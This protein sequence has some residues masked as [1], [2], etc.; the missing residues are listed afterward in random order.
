MVGSTIAVDRIILEL[1]ARLKNVDKL[2]QVTKRFDQV[3]VSVNK[4]GRLID[5][6]SGKMVSFTNT[7]KKL[8]KVQD[9]INKKFEGMNTNMFSFGLSALFTGMAIKRLATG[10]LKAMGNVFLELADAQN[11]GVKRTLELQ[12]AFQF[13]KFALFDALANTDLYASFVGFIIR[14]VRGIID[15]V[16]QNPALAKMFGILLVIG[17]VFGAISMTLGQMTLGFIGIQAGLA[18]MKTNATTAGVAVTASMNGILVPVILLAALL[19]LALKHL[20][21]NPKHVK[22]LR[23]E[24]DTFKETL[25]G[26]WQILSNIFAVFNVELPD[27]GKIAFAL[28]VGLARSFND[29]FRTSLEI[30]QGM[31]EALIGL[32]TFNLARAARGVGQAL[33]ASLRATFGAPFGIIKNVKDVLAEIK[34][35]E[36]LIVTPSTEKLSSNI[37]DTFSPLIPGVQSPNALRSIINDFELQSIQKDL[38]TELSIS[39]SESTEVLKSIQSEGLKLDPVTMRTFAEILAEELINTSAVIAAPE[40]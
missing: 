29:E 7:S 31:I 9:Q 6:A 17:V 14:A 26:F 39:N 5:K 38:L 16:D 11:E 19:F 25:S 36:A 37:G 10:A 28:L 1:D 22:I 40:Q 33:S 27:A 32:S 20:K 12:A 13:L 18:L 4:A 3:G 34:E 30:I 2:N 24:W 35:T 15:F 23:A 8:T 21:D